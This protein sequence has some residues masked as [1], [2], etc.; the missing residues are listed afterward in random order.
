[1]KTAAF[2]ARIL[3]HILKGQKSGAIAR[4]I[5]KDDPVGLAS[6]RA[7]DEAMDICIG[8]WQRLIDAGDEDVLAAHLKEYY[9]AAHRSD[10]D[11]L[12]DRAD[13]IRARRV[14]EDIQALAPTVNPK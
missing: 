12:I 14:S 11:D 8:V 13:E 1:M 4:Y 10:E 2:Q 7:G 3:I 5:F 6:L 9:D